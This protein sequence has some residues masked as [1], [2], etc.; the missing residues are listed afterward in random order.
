MIDLKQLNA[1]IITPVLSQIKLYS[2][3]ARNLVIGTGLQETQ[4]YWVDQTSPGP[5]PGFG[6]FQCERRTHNGLWNNFLPKYPQLMTDVSSLLG[7]YPTDR[8]LAL[9]G[10]WNYATAMCRVH[11]RAVAAP[12]PGARDSR[13]LAQYWKEYY[14]TEKGKGTVEEFLDNYKRW[15]R[16]I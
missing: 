11:Y 8:V 10:N 13:G 14:N 12:L 4:F 16:L 3:A 5:G 15:E 6:P 7:L 9:H 2:D 1:F